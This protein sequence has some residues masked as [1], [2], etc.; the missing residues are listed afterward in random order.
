MINGSKTQRTAGNRDKEKGA[1]TDVSL[2][3]EA[4]FSSWRSFIFSLNRV[5]EVFFSGL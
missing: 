4:G 3:S 5:S 2:C 1:T